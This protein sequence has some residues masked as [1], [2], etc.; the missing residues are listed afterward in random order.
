V[1]AQAG[2]EIAEDQARVDRVVQRERAG[3]G[4]LV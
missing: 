1:Q 4:C 3:E 2:E